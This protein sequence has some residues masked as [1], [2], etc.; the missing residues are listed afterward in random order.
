MKVL[1]KIVLP[2]VL[3]IFAS[4]AT[5]MFLASQRPPPQEREA[6]V[7][8]MLVDVIIAQPSDG[9]FIVQSQGSVQ[10]RTQTSLASEVSGRIVRLNDSFTSGGFFRAGETL[11]EID[12]SDYEAA[13]LQAQAELASAQSRLA[14]EKARSDQARRDWQRLHGSDREP[15]DLVL[16]LPQVAGAQAAVLAAEAGVLRARRNLE[17]TRISMPF[18]GMVRT[19]Q[20]D[21]GQFVSTGSPLGV[22]FAVDVAEIR[23]S[24][25]D[26]E[27]AFLN[28]PEPGVAQADE[29]IPVRL[30]GSVSGR[31]GSWE[32][33]IV[34]TEGVVE[35]STRL[36]N[37][38]AIVEDPYGLLGHPRELPLP[39]G[40]FVSADIQGRS[41]AG[42]IELPRAALRENNTVFLANDRDELEVRSV[43]LMRATTQRAYVRNALKAGD[44]VITTAIQAPIPGLPLRVREATEE[45]PQLRILPAEEGLAHS[46][47]LP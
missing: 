10:P 9:Y 22:V 25:S 1:L 8:A 32:A 39:I 47:E 7:T 6:T 31:R 45:P 21:L 38:V 30:S 5:V 34:R 2:A 23:L 27:L 46:G 19:R 18:D 40:T 14:D 42:L 15:G 24:L 44:R 3:M 35:E 13:L 4:I 33:R 28:L 41:S 20:V 36:V 16:R 11:V 26:Q 17:R 37:A 29:G 12:P 43:E